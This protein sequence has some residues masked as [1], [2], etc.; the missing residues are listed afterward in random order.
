MSRKIIV[1]K[2]GSA[3]LT[4]SVG[5]IAP[6]I[7]TKIAAEISTLFSNYDV[8]LVS[9]G[10]VAS[11]KKYFP[12]YKGTLNERKAAS[13]V[14]NPLLMGH[15]FKKFNLHDR[16]VAQVLCE[17][18]HFSDRKLFVELKETFNQLWQNGI[19]PIVNENDLVSNIELKFSDND[20]LATLLAVGFDAEALVICT[21]AGGFLDDKK[22]TIPIIEKIDQRILSYVRTDKTSIG[23][24]GM[25][26]KLSYTKL[27]MSL[28][29]KV[30]I[31]G[32]AGETPLQLALNG[33][34]GSMF[35]PKE[36]HLR[37]RN[38]WM[39]SSSITIGQIK[40]DKGAEKAI[41]SKH[42][43]LTIGIKEVLGSFMANEFVKLTDETGEVIG[44]AKVKI[45]G[46][47]M[48]KKLSEKH[49][50]A[51]HTDDIVLFD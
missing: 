7:I 3:L 19:L 49:I 41:K 9:S 5:N 34:Y 50:L 40:L 46:A 25:A 32:L 4:N 1:I 6:S 36:I 45:S 22:N 20:E 15:Y 24:G 37:S 14:G 23:L 51:A 44:V 43:L 30:I 16:M 12:H 35:I 18:H 26:S 29:I 31:C 10:A 21:S 48:A 17:R 47:E 28:G 11:G 42:S 39:A 33:K 38:K 8:I 2:V 27:A 13:A